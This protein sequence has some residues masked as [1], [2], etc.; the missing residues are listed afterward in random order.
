MELQI[1][2]ANSPD[3]AIVALLARITFAETFGHLFAEHPTDLKNYLDQTFAVSKIERSLDHAQNAYWLAIADRLPVG[4][5]KLKR[6][7]S[8]PAGYRGDADQLQKIYVLNSFLGRRIGAA[9][10]QPILGEAR[11]RRL[12]L[13]LDVLSENVRA[14]AFYE[15]F[16]FQPIG[17]DK[18][19]IGAQTFDFHL[20][21]RGDP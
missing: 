7:S 11:D 3:A 8:P 17:E 6:S 13:W 9:L 12:L 14:I 1:Q 20:M 15:R 10:M 16:G 5:A 19:T 4:Y 2:R 18:Y 21:A